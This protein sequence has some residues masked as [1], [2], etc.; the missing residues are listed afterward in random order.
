MTPVLSFQDAALDR[1]GRELWRGLTLDVAPGEFLAV[2]GPNGSGK[3]S[4]VRAALGLLPLSAGRLEVLGSP[5]RRGDP[6]IGYVPQQR[7]LDE[8]TPVRGVDLV[9]FGVNGS[10]FGLP[11]PRRRDRER[12][13]ELVEAVGATRIARRPAARLSG[14]E[15]QR[16]RLGQALAADP[17]LLLC[18][19]PLLSLDLANQ[20]IVS[21]LLD[22][23]RRESG[24]AVV[25]VTHDVNPVLE[26]VDRVLYLA[27]GR[28]RIGT[29]EQVLRSEV[30]SDLYGAHVDVVR[31]HDRLVVVGRGH[32]ELEHVGAT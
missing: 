13:T 14:G 8:G 18:D 20:Q 26:M 6:R 4:L 15:Q 28:F 31:V 10:R 1:G 17:A 11:L 24:A 19:E 2:L 9:G 27:G 21:G 30:L 12:V 7:L 29:P 23:H 22:R 32:E 16:L 5:P 25:F 3:T